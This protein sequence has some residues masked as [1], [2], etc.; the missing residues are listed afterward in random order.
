MRQGL[1]WSTQDVE[2]HQFPKLRLK[3]RPNLV[4]LAGGMTAL[5][6]TDPQVSC[7]TCLYDPACLTCDSSALQ[8][9]PWLPL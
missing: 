8:R 4:S 3:F 9:T 7:C 5:P 1:R 6:V 2:G